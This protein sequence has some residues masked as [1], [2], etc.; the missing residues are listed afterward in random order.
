[1]E[2]GLTLTGFL[3]LRGWLLKRDDP[4][5]TDVRVSYRCIDNCLKLIG[6]EKSADY[7]HILAISEHV[8]AHLSKRR[9]IITVVPH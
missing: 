5:A 6:A 2:M 3:S 4:D 1:M 9:D 8:L 7:Y